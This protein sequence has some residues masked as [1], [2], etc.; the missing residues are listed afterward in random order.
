MSNNRIA[1]SE[2]AIARI[3]ED[4]NKSLRSLSTLTLEGKENTP[5]AKAL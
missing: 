5:A 1:Q 3:T 2:A 4:K